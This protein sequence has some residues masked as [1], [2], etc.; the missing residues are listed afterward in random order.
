MS[1]LWRTVRA[2]LVLMAACAAA[3]AQPVAPSATVAALEPPR[4]V[5]VL[6]GIP[7][8]HF[9]PE[10][11]YSSGYGD[12]AG[13]KA[14]RRLAASLAAQHGLTLGIDWPMPSIGLHCYVMDVPPRDD[15]ADIAAEL[16]R[17]PRVS[18][19]QAVH[20]FRPLGHDD[21][22]FDLQPA[23][24]E[25][26]L[27]ELHAVAT[28]FG[29]RVAVI[30]S[31]VQTDH[32]DLAGQ[33]V[34]NA[35]YTG[36]AASAGERHGTAVAGLIAALADNRT[37]IVGVAPQARLHALRACTQGPSGDTTTC[38]TLPLALALN[39][40]IEQSDQII[41]LSLGGPE[42]RL[43]RR[44]VEAAL[45][46]G[47]DVVA[48]ADPSAADGGFP[49]RLH[50]VVAVA[51]A[52]AGPPRDALLAP[53]TD[54][55]TTVPPSRWAVLSGAS[56]AAAQVS[57]L[58]ALI[59]GEQARNGRVRESSGTP[60]ATLSDGRIDACASLARAGAPCACTCGRTTPQASVSHR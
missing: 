19:A 41:N 39:T 31:A 37:G 8:P 29:V 49:A 32:P 38:A 48:A 2:L 3:S 5:L 44:L 7:A 23:A 14:R 9:R 30:D 47:I 56:Y 15:P 43:I 12:T 58:L 26:H 45:A 1:R 54:V 35:D 21:L 55:L 33:V 28:G 4:Q 25:W 10:A 13:R 20:L 22:L 59:R 57:G 46:R 50:G 24:R 16:A 11:N 42:D 18:W 51:Q 60:L 17:D 52:G 34:S 6:L 53:G 36:E 27:D 40:A